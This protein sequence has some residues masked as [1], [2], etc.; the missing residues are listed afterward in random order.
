MDWWMDGGVEG[1]FITT[2]NEKAALRHEDLFSF[3]C[4]ISGGKLL[5]IWVLYLQFVALLSNKANSYSTTQSFV[6]PSWTKFPKTIHEQVCRCFWKVVVKNLFWPLSN[7][8]GGITASFLEDQFAKTTARVERFILKFMCLF[9][10]II[11][12]TLVYLNVTQLLLNIPEYSHS[13][14]DRTE[15]S[16]SVKLI[17]TPLMQLFCPCGFLKLNL[18]LSRVSEEQWVDAVLCFWI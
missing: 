4:W 16:F 5:F 9:P 17:K 12:F 6:P 8:S 3:G 14:Q 11:W 2:S 15:K 13:S 18:R 1:L 7:S 10:L